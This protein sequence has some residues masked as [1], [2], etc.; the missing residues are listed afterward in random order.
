VLLKICHALNVNITDIMESVEI[1]ESDEP[2][3]AKKK[4]AM[5]TTGTSNKKNK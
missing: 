1:E 4:T 3:P 2:Q 5:K